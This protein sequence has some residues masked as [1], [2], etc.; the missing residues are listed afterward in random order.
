[1]GRFLNPGNKA[2]QKT[3]KSEI[4]VDKTM[5]LAYTNKVIG[6]DMACIC[7]S[8]PR[9]FGKSI[10]ANM[11]AAYYSRGCDS[12]DMFST[13]KVGRLDSFE[14]NLNKYDVIHIDVQWCMMD[15]GEV[16]NTVKYINNGILDELII[17]YG[18]VIPDT[19]KTAY[20][21]MSYIN[22]ATGNTFVIIIDEW[23]VLIRDEANNKEL[24]EGYINFLR[25]MFKGTEPTKYIALA[26]LTGILPIKKLKTQ[27]ALNNFEEFT[28]LDA[29]A[30]AS[31][32]GFTDDEVKQLCKK[33]DRDYEAVKNWYDGYMLSGKHVYNPKAVV[34]VMMRGSFQSYWSQ[35]GTY[36]S[37]IP[38]I[39]MD[40]DGLRA[41]I[42]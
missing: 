41:A 36:E 11:L 38:L 13:L 19:V 28:M 24:Q 9:R 14:T 15:A 30:L 3:L 16:Q 22:A 33:Y 8:R 23:D 29:G 27:S 31:Y 1:M 32:I 37:L 18:D 5:L 26:Y 25:G 17:A 2:F 10:T 35:T 6:S 7:N 12:F 20:G 40:F 42:I 39:D 4:Y 21:A 34:S